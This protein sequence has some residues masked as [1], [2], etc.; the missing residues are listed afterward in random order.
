MLMLPLFFLAQR[1]LFDT[2]LFSFTTF[3][4]SAYATIYELNNLLS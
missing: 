1:Y 4:L 2:H 3:K